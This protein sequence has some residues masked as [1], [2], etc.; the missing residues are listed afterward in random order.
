LTW[1]PTDSLKHRA[2]GEHLSS[3]D[4]L[5]LLIE[6]SDELDRLGFPRNGESPSRRQD[7]K[8]VVEAS[9]FDR[10]RAS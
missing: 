9:G 8:V 2:L 5:V 3:C 10:R 1:G 6:L 4:L 7:D